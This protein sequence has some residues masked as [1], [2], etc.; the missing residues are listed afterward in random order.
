MSAF[1]TF[2]KKNLNLRKQRFG[3]NAQ[4]MR[5]S[6]KYIIQMKMLNFWKCRKGFLLK[7]QYYFE[8]V[9]NAAEKIVIIKKLNPIHSV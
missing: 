7:S 8:K 4:K 6:E 3:V 1:E 9:A 2:L 5:I